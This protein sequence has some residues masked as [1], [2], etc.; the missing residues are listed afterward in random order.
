MFAQRYG[1][2]AEALKAVET[3]RYQLT[4]QFAIKIAVAVGVDVHSLLENHDPLVDWNGNPVTAHTQPAVRHLNLNADDRLGFLIDSAFHAARKHPKGDRSALFVVLFDYWLVDVV[5]ELDIQSEFWDEL[6][7]YGDK[8]KLGG[9]PED[10][11]QETRKYVELPEEVR[12][13]DYGF[14]E[15]VARG[16]ALSAVYDMEQKRLLLEY[17]TPAEIAEYNVPINWKL[18]DSKQGDPKF[19]APERIAYRRFAE[20]KGIDPDNED[21]VR[22]AFLNEAWR[23]FEEKEEKWRRGED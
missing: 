9:N 5:R 11:S 15:F 22:D 21:A 17:L 19:G 4:Q 2:S 18:V 7:A 12:W 13:G 3:G 16:L 23:R 14:H 8:F 10:Q 6:F 20:S 1:V